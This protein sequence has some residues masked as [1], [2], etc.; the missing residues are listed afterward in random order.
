[1]DA[2]AMSQQDDARA[3]CFLEKRG[4]LYAIIEL[5]VDL[6]S[7]TL[8]LFRPVKSLT[9][10]PRAQKD[11]AFGTCLG[12]VPLSQILTHP[13]MLGTMGHAD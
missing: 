1:M 2:S 10:G 7:R 11:T 12:P 8:P 3:K 5:P 6:L 9:H 13:I 4:V